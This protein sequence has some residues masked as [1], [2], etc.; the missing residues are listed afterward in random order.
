[1]LFLTKFGLSPDDAPWG[2]TKGL[3]HHD[4]GVLP[5]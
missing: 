4:E 1:M 5:K 3:P 2:V